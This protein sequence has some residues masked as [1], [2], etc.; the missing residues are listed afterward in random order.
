MDSV[1]NKNLTTSLMKSSFH[2]RSLKSFE[3]F[4]RQT[5]T[6]C[7]SIAW[8]FTVLIIGLSLE[9]MKLINLA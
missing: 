3:R 4:A 8:G 2:W 9:L 7:R 1:A 5:W 6:T